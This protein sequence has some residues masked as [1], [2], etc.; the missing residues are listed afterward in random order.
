MFA[1]SLIFEGFI[2]PSAFPFFP[3]HFFSVDSL[4]SVWLT[5]C[6]FIMAGN[7]SV[8]NLGLADARIDE[9]EVVNPKQEQTTPV[10]QE[11][12]PSVL[13]GNGTIYLDS[14]ITFENYAYWAKRS[15][16]VEKSFSTADAGFASLGNV[17]LGKKT[18]PA[19]SQSQEVPVI[20]DAAEKNSDLP[21]TDETNTA[22]AT[23]SWGI[24]ESEWSM[25]SELYELHPGARS[26]I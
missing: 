24:T 6:K 18:A 25:P 9:A 4:S 15:R 3:L 17:L 11:V 19:P 22:D 16:E 7:I 14:S 1:W 2:R 20:T 12:P 10:S 23:D 5:C 13:H 8:T 26:F 21:P